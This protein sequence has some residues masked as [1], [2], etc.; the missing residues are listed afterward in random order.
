[1][2]VV[3]GVTAVTRPLPF[4]VAT[5]VLDD[6]QMTRVVITWVVPS[7]Y[8]PEAVNCIVFDTGTLGFAGVMDMEDRV[9]RFM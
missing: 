8:A 2:V 7:E 5:D 4:T 3:P 9:A 6:L 1:M